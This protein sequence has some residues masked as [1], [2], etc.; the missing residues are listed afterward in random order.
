MDADD[1]LEEVGEEWP[2]FEEPSVARQ[3]EFHQVSHSCIP[4]HTSLH[5]VKP[6]GI[7]LVFVYQFSVD[8]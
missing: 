4:T 2:D 8:K 7:D 6:I 5:A 3:R 1:S